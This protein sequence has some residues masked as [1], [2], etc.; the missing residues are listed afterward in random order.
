MPILTGAENALA[1]GQISILLCE[2]RGDAIREA[3]YVRTLL[4]R[5]VDGIIVTGRSSDARPSLVLDR[6]VPVVYALGPS[7]DSR[8]HSVIPDDRAGAARAIQ[9]LVARGKRTIAIVAGPR[10]HLANQHRVDSAARTIQQDTTTQLITPLY[11]DWTESWGRDAAATLL[12]QNPEIDGIFCTNDQIARGVLEHLREASI[13]VPA[14]IAVVGFDNWDVMVEASRPPLTSVD[15]NLGEVGR[16]AAVRL[17]EAVSGAV[18][19]PGI[20]YVDCELIPRQST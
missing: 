8:D 2:T 15:L 18:L 3:H 20:E 12:L 13:P 4:E 7:N 6:H 14:R 10:R 9:H 16:V 11:G 5:R 17:L 19:E 1:A